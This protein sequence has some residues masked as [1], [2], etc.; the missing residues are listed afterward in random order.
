MSSGR[1][2]F[3]KMPVSIWASD[4]SRFTNSTYFSLVAC[5]NLSNFESSCV[6]VTN[7]KNSKSLLG[8]LADYLSFG[9]K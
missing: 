5:M 7:L 3:N 8:F 6:F 2:F 4:Y 9:K 1:F